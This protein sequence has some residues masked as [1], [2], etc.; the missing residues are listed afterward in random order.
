MRWSLLLL[1]LLCS[2]PGWGPPPAVAIAGDATERATPAL[3]AIMGAQGDAAIA[4]GDDPRQ[5]VLPRWASFWAAWKI[6]VAAQNAWATA[7][8]ARASNLGQ[9]EAAARGA[10]CRAAEVLPDE[11]PR[12]VVATTAITCGVLRGVP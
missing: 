2:C 12:Q 10:F 9:V 5:T 11:V 1:L 8:E 3:V 6:W 4:R 7:Y